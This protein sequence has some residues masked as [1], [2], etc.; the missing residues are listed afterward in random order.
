MSELLTSEEWTEGL[1]APLERAAGNGNRDLVQKLVEAGA[2][3]GNALP[4]LFKGDM[5]TLQT[6][7][8]TRR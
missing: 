7:C 4:E 6:I 5:K 2:E 3:I 8:K 1:T